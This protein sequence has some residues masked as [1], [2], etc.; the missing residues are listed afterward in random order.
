MASP[1]TSTS[2]GPSDR[3]RARFKV[4]LSFR[5]EDTRH[6]FTDHLYAALTRTA[7]HTF[8]DDDEIKTGQYLE[9]KIVEAIESSRASIVVLSETYAKSRWCLEELSLIL[10][11]KRK[12]NHF[13]LP[14]FYKVDPSHVR[15]QRHSFAIEETKWTE[16][17][18]NRWKSA[19]TEVANLKGMVASGSETKFIAN[20]VDTI[21]YELDMK[22]IST[23]ANLTGVETRAKHINSWLK[24]EHSKTNVLA[25]C[26]MGGSG[27]TTLARYIY[28]LHKHDFESSSFLEEIGNRCQENCGMLGLQRQFLTDIL[29]G[30]NT[31]ISCVP[32]GTTKI[33]EALHMKKMLIVLDDID[34]HDRLGAL[35]GTSV[36]QTQSKI[37]ITTRLLDIRSWFESISWRCLV[38]QLKLLDD[39]E[40]LKLLS[41]HAFGSKLPLEG[42]SGL[43]VELAN[44]G[45]NLDL[46]L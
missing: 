10:E 24:D 29:G 15:H 25:I 26:G 19:L 27:K 33:K 22:L 35:L 1:S 30:Q 13:V 12:G 3:N 7:I 37:I 42:F 21:S 6:S 41:W 43:A 2:M 8:R 40:S 9:P 28:N 45:P 23:L 11:Q 34:D 36:V 32:E 44:V 38:H 31:M 14:V 5:G 39:H 20:I 16:V 4:F 46:D 17:D 18:V